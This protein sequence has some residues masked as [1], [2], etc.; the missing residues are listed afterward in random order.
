MTIDKINALAER[1]AADLFENGNGEHAQRL[2]M[3]M[4][5]NKLEGSGW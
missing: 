5:R 2:V 3:E 1:I 4:P